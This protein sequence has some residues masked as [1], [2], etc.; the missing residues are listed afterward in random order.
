[1]S[2]F[3]SAAGVLGLRASEQTYKPFK[4]R[5]CVPCSPMVPLDVS[6]DGFQSQ[7]FWGH[8]SLVQVL[9]VGSLMFGIE[10]SL[11]REKFHIC[12]VPPSCASL[13]WVWG[14]LQDC[15]S[16]SPTHLDVAL[17]TFVVRE[18]SARFQVIFRGN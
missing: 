13:H 16:A 1:M 18:F 6:P 14:S 10:H 12:E 9:R 17:L 15:A 7:M 8:V 5:I 2:A 11:L 3:Q 4:S